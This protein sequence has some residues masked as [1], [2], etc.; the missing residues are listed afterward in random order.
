MK[1]ILDENKKK[2]RKKNLMKIIHLCKRVEDQWPVEKKDTEY[3][4]LVE[5]IKN[6]EFWNLIDQVK[7]IDFA[8]PG[9]IPLL[10]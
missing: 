6:S 9:V 8:E 5:K 10:Y 7:E 1:V 4:L 3:K 2:E